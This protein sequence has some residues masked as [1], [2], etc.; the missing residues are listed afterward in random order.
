MILSAEVPSIFRP[1]L[2][3]VFNGIIKLLKVIEFTSFS[4]KALSHTAM[5]YSLSLPK[6][7]VRFHGAPPIIILFGCP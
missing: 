1:L 2:L 5:L 7:L 6:F 4:F 3:I